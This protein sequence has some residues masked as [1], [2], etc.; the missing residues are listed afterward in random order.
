M[1]QPKARTLTKSETAILFAGREWLN[2]QR[3]SVKAAKEDYSAALRNAGVSK[4]LRNWLMKS[5]HNDTCS[6]IASWGTVV[7]GGGSPLEVTPQAAQAAI[8]KGASEAS[9]RLVAAQG[10]KAL[11]DSLE[12]LSVDTDEQGNPTTEALTDVI[13][14]GGDLDVIE[15]SLCAPGGPRAAARALRNQAA[16]VDESSTV[17]LKLK[18]WTTFKEA[19]LSQSAGELGGLRV[20]L[21][22]HLGEV[23]SPG[24]PAIALNL[25]AYM[26]TKG[27][28]ANQL[29]KDLKMLASDFGDIIILVTGLAAAV[30][31]NGDAF[32]SEDGRAG[33]TALVNSL[34]QSLADYPDIKLRLDH[35]SPLISTWIGA[36][37]IGCDPVGALVVETAEAP[38]AFSVCAALALARSATETE[39]Q[40]VALRVLGARKLDQID[41]L[42]RNRLEERG[43]PSDALDRV[44]QALED[45]L[46]LK[47]AFSRWVIGDEIIRRRL[48]LAPEAFETDGEALL[49]AL[50]ISNREIED[51]R[52]AIAGRR[53]P[54]SDP[55][56]P[57][58]EIL[59]TQKN[60]DTEARIS[61]AEAVRSTFDAAVP[62]SAMASNEQALP[63][64]DLSQIF[65]AAARSDLSIFIAPSQ[66]VLTGEIL[67]RLEEAERRAHAPPKLAQ[68]GP[69]TP[70]ADART[71]QAN[72]AAKTSAT[73]QRQRLPD[74]RKG[75]IQKSTVGGHKVY[76]HT[77]EF[78][79]GELGEIFIDMHKEGAA[80]RSLMNNFAIAVS[81]G[82]QYGVPLEEFVDAF[83]FT[84]FDPAGEVTGNDSIRS[85]TSILDYIFRELA[86]SYLDRQDLAEMNHLSSDGL[87][88]GED[89]TPKNT[90][91][92]PQDAA[93]LI[94]KGFSRGAIPD[95]I[96]MFNQARSTPSHLTS[97]HH[98]VRSDQTDDTAEDVT[99]LGDAC[100][101]C[102]HFTLVEDDGIA[103]CD[104]CGA[105]VQT[106]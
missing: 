96:I 51:A 89:E 88:R 101:N 61:F 75:Y 77:G 69:V 33:A 37:S 38:P 54:I 25:R 55:K 46:S 74:R 100:P 97:M 23:L 66:P 53:R 99:Y 27:F 14:C 60:T 44:E 78:E 48:S 22:L 98:E 18:D 12:G 91:A 19:N 35:P 83:V 47:G 29:D 50:G 31:A 20:G 90:P 79:D 8:G 76:L 15:T 11:A 30:M 3:G 64:K 71:I 67:E 94:S 68:T 1:P 7:S 56:S 106:A 65:E 5:D 21:H 39:R 81:I 85:A 36:E 73:A 59:S 63:S 9:A 62:I 84:R 13:R 16:Q 34:K 40:D 92:T 49:S 4:E 93:R 52:K 58:A 10:F 42:E 82:L 87:G 32:A 104:A 70:V 24:H 26:S 103:I 72:L 43:L 2:A 28:E 102:G 6:P 17:H 95:N 45:G 57:L 105:T 86:V 41:G 80:F